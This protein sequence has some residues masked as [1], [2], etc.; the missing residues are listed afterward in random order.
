MHGDI[1][2]QQGEATLASAEQQFG[3]VELSTG[4][5]VS[6]PGWAIEAKTTMSGDTEPVQRICTSQAKPTGIQGRSTQTARRHQ[7]STTRLTSQRASADRGRRDE[8][9]GGTA[10]LAQNI[11]GHAPTTEAGVAQAVGENV[12]L[13]DRPSRDVDGGQQSVDCEIADQ[14]TP[15]R[16]VQRGLRTHQPG[17]PIRGRLRNTTAN[18]ANV[19]PTGPT[20]RRHVNWVL[21]R[22]NRVPNSNGRQGHRAYR[23][24]VFPGHCFRRYRLDSSQATAPSTTS[25]NIEQEIGRGTAGRNTIALRGRTYGPRRFPRPS[26]RGYR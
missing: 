26:F 12:T 15:E 7:Q 23:P 14:P 20:A 13:D 2:G 3:D 19:G 10:P 4:D 9:E 18:I 24:R 25:G 1:E 5:S 22:G 6:D 16:M 8:R 21:R 17:I 11:E